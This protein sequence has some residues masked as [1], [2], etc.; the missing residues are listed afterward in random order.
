[1]YTC[2]I[3]CNAVKYNVDRLAEP[4][5]LYAMSIWDTSYTERRVWVVNTPASYSGSP[6]S[7]LSL[8]IGYP[9]WVFFVV[10]PSSSRQMLG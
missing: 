5:R 8:E 10:F 3:S 6:G 1:V 4:L 2:C 7:N 9:D